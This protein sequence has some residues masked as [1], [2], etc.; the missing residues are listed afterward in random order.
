MDTN[1]T[2]RTTMFKTVSAYLDDNASVWN[3]MAPLATAVTEF[4]GKI[5]EIDASALKQ[6][7]PRGR[8]RRQSGGAR[9]FG[10]RLVSQLRSPGRPVTPAMIMTFRP[11]PALRLQ[12]CAG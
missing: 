2:N 8:D 7:T 12:A 10:R 5:A 3:G 4:K 9:S 11:S 6:E 1:Q